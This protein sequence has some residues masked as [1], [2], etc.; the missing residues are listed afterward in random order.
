MIIDENF[1]KYEF[2]YNLIGRAF[3]VRSLG[4]G[5]VTMTDHNRWKHKRALFNNGFLRR[6]VH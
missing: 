4:D 1:P 5:L 6:Y 2:V 3:G